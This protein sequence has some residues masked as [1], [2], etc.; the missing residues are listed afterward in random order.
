M[1]FY[2]IIL[3]CFTVCLSSCNQK[4]TS[5]QTNDSTMHVT[6]PHTFA[7]PDEAVVK[8]LD[9][10]ITIDF[11]QKIL[12]GKATCEIEKKNNAQ[13]IILDT[14]DLTIEKV[15]LDGNEN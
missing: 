15:K 1:K 13:Q 12:S 10:D 3:S 6:D 7:R 5:N 11:E 14:R 9:L 2:V 4:Q 8:H